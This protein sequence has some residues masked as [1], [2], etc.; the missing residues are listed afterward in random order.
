[1]RFLGMNPSTGGGVYLVHSLFPKAQ[2]LVEF[3]AKKP[4]R[5]QVVSHLSRELSPGDDRCAVALVQLSKEGTLHCIA[6]DGFVVHDP[7]SINGV[8]IESD[9][10]SSLA[11]RN[12]ELRVFASKEFERF[13]AL[14]AEC[15][16]EVWSSGA[17]IPIGTH[18]MYFVL[19][20][21]DVTKVEHFI[22]YLSC[23]ASLLTVVEQEFRERNGRGRTEWFQDD[24]KELTER[25]STIEKFIR[26][27][28]TNAQIAERLG[29]SESLIRQET[30]IIYRKLGVS[31]RKDLIEGSRRSKDKGRDAIQAVLALSGF[32][33][34]SQL[35]DVFASLDSY[36]PT[37]F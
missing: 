28:L 35:I 20:K 33:L 15:E 11:M 21:N 31:G 19:F 30:V 5:A 13:I 37:M 16:R 6:A 1:M 10:P 7:F 36:I 24:V 8:R 2:S 26:D 4:V 25:E 9:R 18:M 22:E 27:G 23:M 29:Y 34:L 32:E 3:I 17:T 14:I 12:P